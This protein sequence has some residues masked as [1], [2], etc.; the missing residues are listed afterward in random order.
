MSAPTRPLH[1]DSVV[2]AAGR[3][4]PTPG[5]PVNPPVVLSSTYVSQGLPGDGEK[6]YA[7]S[8]TETWHAPEEVIGRLEGAGQPAVLFASGMAAIVAAWSLVPVGGRIVMP[9]VPYQMAGVLADDAVAR[10]RAHVTRVDIADT[11]AVA[12]AVAAAP[13]DLV[14]IESPTNPLLDVADVPA[15]VEIAHGAGALVGVDNTFATPLGQQPLAWGA[16]LVVH[17]VTKY[18]AGH[19]DVVLGAVAAATPRLDAALRTHRTLTGS[20][21]GPW[22]AWLALRGMRTLALRVARSTASAA[23]LSARLAADPRTLRV[24]HP[25]LPDDP[26]HER[27]ARLMANFGSVIGLELPGGPDAADALIA[28]TTL[29]VPATS[30]GGV[31]SLLERRRRFPT[32]SPDV[33]ESLIRLSVGIENP[34]DLW[35]DLDQALG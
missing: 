27:A 31:E 24:R 28:A 14:W 8:D 13:V 21:P 9:R 15:L 17:S 5:A 22:E 34:D 4:A 30:L 6:V 25:S 12:A 23:D 32:E 35:A 26:G 3:P 7:R 29:W 19:S 16:D 33:P 1:P 10:R 18:L 11:E 20:I 2:V